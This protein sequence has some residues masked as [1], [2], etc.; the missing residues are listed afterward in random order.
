MMLFLT[1]IKTDWMPEE[2]KRKKIS[3][4]YGVQEQAKPYLVHNYDEEK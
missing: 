2:K 3:Y 4:T 1:S